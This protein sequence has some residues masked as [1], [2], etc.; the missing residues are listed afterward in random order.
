MRHHKWNIDREGLKMY[1][2]EVGLH[3]FPVLRVIS[4][5]RFYHGCYNPWT[6][7]ITICLNPVSPRGLFRVIGQFFILPE[8]RQEKDRLDIAWVLAHELGHAKSHAENRAKGWTEAALSA[9]FVGFGIGFLRAYIA[10]QIFFI[11]SVLAFVWAVY[12][13]SP[14]ERRADKFAKK[15]W[16]EIGKFIHAI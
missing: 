14:A 7:R 12:F 16:I 4:S 1:M 15:H 5:P 3:S 11:V 10:H 8:R 6:Q 13:L 2:S 9:A